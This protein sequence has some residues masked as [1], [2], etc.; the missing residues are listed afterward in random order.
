MNQLLP[1]EIAK[2][3][4]Q[5]TQIRSA[6]GDPEKLIAWAEKLI[7]SFALRPGQPM[8]HAKTGN[9]YRVVDTGI[10]ESR[11]EAGVLY[12]DQ[13]NGRKWFRPIVEFYDQVNVAAEGQPK[14]MVQRFRFLPDD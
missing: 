12:Q 6:E 3:L 1:N 10:H 13:S 2:L 4:F 14:K 9:L 7:Q 5:N 11:L 8:Q